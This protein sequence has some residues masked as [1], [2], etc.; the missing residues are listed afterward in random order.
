MLSLMGYLKSF[1]RARLY[2]RRELTD[3]RERFHNAGPTARLCLEWDP[4]TIEWFYKTRD[5]RIEKIVTA[6]LFEE[7]INA[8]ENL[9]GG[10][11]VFHLICLVYRSDPHKMHSYAV[12]PITRS[13][14]RRL[15]NQLWKL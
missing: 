11:D 13:V 7:V 12:D 2:P 8:I 3:I 15:R 4:V 14:G 9:H 10:D 6:E 5:A 1:C